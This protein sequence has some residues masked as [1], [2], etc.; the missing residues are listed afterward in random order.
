[1][2]PAQA[3]PELMTSHF[4]WFMVPWNAHSI[5]DPPGVERRRGRWLERFL[6]LAAA[7]EL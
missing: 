5:P 4:F 7:A 3:P 6:D 1:M 2:T